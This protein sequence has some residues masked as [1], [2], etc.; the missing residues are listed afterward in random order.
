VNRIKLISFFLDCFSS[1]ISKKILKKFNIE[2]ESI[3]G[4][5]VLK[6]SLIDGINVPKYSKKPFYEKIK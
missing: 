5:N 2:S 6:F 4:E 3:I 1:E